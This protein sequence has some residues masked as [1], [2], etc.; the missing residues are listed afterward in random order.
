MSKPTEDDLKAAAQLETME[1]MAAI[2][3]T[4]N[5]MILQADFDTYLRLV[6]RAESWLPM[7]DP[8][9]YMKANLD[10]SAE[11]KKIVQAYKSLQDTVM[12]AYDR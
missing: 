8:T 9:A 6:E 11:Y 4:C 1:R 10:S 3:K 12:E 2:I 5:M 7:I